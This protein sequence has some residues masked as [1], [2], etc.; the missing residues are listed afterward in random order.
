DDGIADGADQFGAGRDEPGKD[1]DDAATDGRHQHVLH[2]V[3]EGGKV[4]DIG[5]AIEGKRLVV[6]EFLHG[7]CRDAP[8]RRQGR[9]RNEWHQGE[10]EADEQHHAEQA[11]RIKTPALERFH[12]RLIRWEA[13][14]WW[15]AGPGDAKPCRRSSKLSR[16]LAV[17][18]TGFTPTLP[19]RSGR[20]R[21][22]RTRRN[23]SWPQ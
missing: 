20:R 13:G 14:A 15:T 8:G 4:A 1:A 23:I 19:W 17:I 7:G 12:C 22:S 21:G 6:E 11:E 5:K 3:D 16:N 10:P 2:G 9:S 18:A